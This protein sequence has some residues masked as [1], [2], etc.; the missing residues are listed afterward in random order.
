MTSRRLVR[1]QW[2]EASHGP[3]CGSCSHRDSAWSGPPWTALDG[4]PS[5]RSRLAA[6]KFGDPL[7]PATLCTIPHHFT[8]LAR[9]A[10]LGPATPMLVKSLPR[11]VL[12]AF[13]LL[14]DF[15]AGPQHVPL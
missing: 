13:A 6:C 9:T 11:L 5:P 12:L 8:E 15:P 2:P 1:A 10:S 4:P 14:P 7:H 3:R